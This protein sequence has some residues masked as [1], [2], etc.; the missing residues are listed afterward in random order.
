M[1]RPFAFV[2][3]A[4]YAAN[5]ANEI[6]ASMPEPAYFYAVLI[7]TAAVAG[8]IRGFAGFGGPLVMLPV[9][10]L[11]L[12]PAASVP[13][14]MWIDL[15]VN[16][17]LLRGGLRNAQTSVVVPLTLGTLIAMPL[18][19]LA[20]IAADPMLMKRGI[21]AAILVAAIVLLTGWRYRGAITAPGW[22]GVGALAGLVMGATSLAVTAA[23]F[24]NA[25]TQTAAQ[26][27]ANFIVWVFIASLALLAMLA[28]GTGFDGGLLRPIAILAPPYLAGSL[29]GSRLNLSAPEALVRRAVLLLVVAV[30]LTGLAV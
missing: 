7:P 23:L 6:A 16:V 17:G 26:S 15:L 25:G 9:L 19:V 22:T 27:R 10:T 1:S 28:V 24:L 13:A 2:R 3:R 21:S 12:P 29:V 18:G 8:F 4:S 30:A 20:L 14:M 5:S 11:F